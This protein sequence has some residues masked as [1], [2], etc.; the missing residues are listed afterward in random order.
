ME[1][2]CDKSTLLLLVTHGDGQTILDL[3]VFADVDDCS[4]NGPAT[5]RPI[6]FADLSKVL[7][8]LGSLDDDSM[9]QFFERETTRN[10]NRH[11]YFL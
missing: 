6:S 4:D 11:W 5:D 7:I 3:I 8:R 2:F 9:T 10:C 1:L